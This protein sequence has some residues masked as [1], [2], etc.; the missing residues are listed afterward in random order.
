M[1]LADAVKEGLW[2]KNFIN[3][4]NTGIQFDSLPIH[5]D[6]ESAIK[7]SKNPEINTRSKHIDIRHHFLRDHVKNNK[8][9]IV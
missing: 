8:I 5:V 1:A 6:N 7:L 9:K 4:L 3:D 2:I